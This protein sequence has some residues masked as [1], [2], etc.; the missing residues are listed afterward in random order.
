MLFDTVCIIIWYR[1]DNQTVTFHFI[2]CSCQFVVHG[3]AVAWYGGRAICTY[4]RPRDSGR[5]S[6]EEEKIGTHPQV[7]IE[8]PFFTPAINIYQDI[9]IS[10]FFIYRLGFCL[11]GYVS[12]MLCV[13]TTTVAICIMSLR[14]ARSSR[15]KSN[16]IDTHYKVF[17]L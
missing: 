9:P 5:P 1:L 12:V 7:L 4:H 10:I 2:L 16:Y 15:G 14:E 17:I 11:T 8:S 3:I 6:N 13:S